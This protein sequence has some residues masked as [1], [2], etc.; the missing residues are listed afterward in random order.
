MRD[1]RQQ[2]RIMEKTSALLVID[3]Q[4]DF[5]PGGSLAVSGGDEIIPTINK[6]IKLF[7]REGLPVMASRDWHPPNTVHF[8]TGG[9]IWPVHCVQNTEGA[10]FHPD[11][12]LPEEVVILSKGMNP[13]RDDEY[14]NFH[15]VTENGLH[16]TEFLR[17]QGITRLYICG[18][19]T[20]YC[21][22]STVLDALS[23]GFAVTLLKDAVCGVDL[24]QG[25]SERAIAEMVSSG[26][27]VAEYSFLDESR[28]G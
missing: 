10:K 18:I 23:G 8:K 20:D 16:F 1:F 11:L 28:N 27:A 3:V 4:N 13:A 5:C 14:S 24:N 21:V 25:D 2:E 26:A 17:K 12:A 15:A 6:Y 22:K 7:V 19:A 9:G